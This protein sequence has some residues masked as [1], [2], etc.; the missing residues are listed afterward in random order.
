[1]KCLCLLTVILL[2]SNFAHAQ[3][4]NPPGVIYFYDNSGNR[5]L[6]RVINIGERL[7]SPATFQGQQEANRD[8]DVLEEKVGEY[9][10]IA[11]PNPTQNVVNVQAPPAFLELGDAR[12]VIY[13]SDGKLLREDKILGSHTAINFS[14]YAN[15]QYILKILAGKEHVEWQIIKN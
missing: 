7:A 2:F 4:P 11:Y 6:R 9:S 12:Y 15:G 1:M 5:V 3:T 8:R 14:Q 10:I 13:E